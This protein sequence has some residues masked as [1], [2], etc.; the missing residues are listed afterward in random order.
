MQAVTAMDTED[1]DPPVLIDLGPGVSSA[2][3][4]VALDMQDLS[5]SKVPLTLITGM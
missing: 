4:Q 2:P 3:D 1:E 5:L